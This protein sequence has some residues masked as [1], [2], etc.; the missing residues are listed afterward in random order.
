MPV[1]R[2]DTTCGREISVHQ[3]FS[4]DPVEGLNGAE[5][6]RLPL[7]RAVADGLSSHSTN[8]PQTALQPNLEHTILGS[9]PH[10]CMLT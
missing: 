7:L 2:S 10:I 1:S 8:A 9:R 4:R 6:G 5:L 3:R